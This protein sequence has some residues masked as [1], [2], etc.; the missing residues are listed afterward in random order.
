MRRLAGDLPIVRVLNGYQPARILP[1]DDQQATFGK[2]LLAILVAAVI[3]NAASLK[4]RGEASSHLPL[5]W[6]NNK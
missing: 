6:I 3:A 4:K 2:R 1:A 5:L